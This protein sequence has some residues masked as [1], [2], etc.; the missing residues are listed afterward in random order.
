MALAAQIH[1][2]CGSIH[3][4]DQCEKMYKQTVCG[5]EA[6]KRLGFDINE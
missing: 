3:D 6:A 2:E 4:S 1:E 5:H